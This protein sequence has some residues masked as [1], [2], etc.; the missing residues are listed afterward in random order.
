MQLSMAH[1]LTGNVG[2]LKAKVRH[3]QHISDSSVWNPMPNN[4]ALLMA[5]VVKASDE[6]FYN[7]NSRHL[8]LCCEA[9]SL[10]DREN[11]VQE[12]FLSCERLVNVT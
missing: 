10:R 4:C 2:Y 12:I 7:A 1:G 11:S 3:L 9:C 8:K 5:C 6:S